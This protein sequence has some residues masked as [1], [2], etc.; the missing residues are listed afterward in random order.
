[1]LPLKNR[2][3]LI[4]DDTPAIHQD[5]QKIL[6]PSSHASA[7]LKD[8]ESVL[9]GEKRPATSAEQ[10]Y[11]IDSAL[12]GQG[13]LVMVTHAV[14]VN[15]PY[16]LVIVDMR[17]PPGWDGVDTIKHIIEVCPAVELCICSAYSDYSWHEVVR[18][19]GRTGLRLL[20]KPFET[21]EVRAM[22]HELTDKWQRQNGDRAVPKSTSR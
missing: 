16:A 6:A 17:M 20:R 10:V 2:R 12:Q 22:V 21:H 13:G 4:I 14:R 5:F 8:D 7:S 18:R 15:R 3:I 11:E 19:L 9:F 1:M